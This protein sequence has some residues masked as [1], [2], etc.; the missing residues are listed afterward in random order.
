MK[1][2]INKLLYKKFNLDGKRFVKIIQSQRK[3][4]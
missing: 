2:Y 3:T 4:N 1:Y